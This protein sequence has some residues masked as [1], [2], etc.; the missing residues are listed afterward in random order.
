MWI[1]IENPF[2]NQENR[3]RQGFGLAPL[4]DECHAVTMDACGC[5][6]W[7]S[8]TTRPPEALMRILKSR[9]HVVISGR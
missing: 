6:S 5:R 3:W 1:R 9:D 7:F 8:T 2:G 4:S